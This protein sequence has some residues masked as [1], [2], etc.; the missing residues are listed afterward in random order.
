MSNTSL[1]SNTSLQV[2]LLL[3]LLLLLLLLTLHPILD[4]N[5]QMC[6]LSIQKYRKNKINS[7][8]HPIAQLEFNNLY[9]FVLC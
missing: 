9:L 1:S 8:T 3:F 7:N 6:S 5:I 4:N 2:S